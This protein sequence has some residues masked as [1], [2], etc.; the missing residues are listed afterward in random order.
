MHKSCMNCYFGELCPDVRVCEHFAPM[1]EDE[2]GADEALK[3]RQEYQQYRKAWIAYLSED[4]QGASPHR[5]N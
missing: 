5:F 3:R 1:E 4:G 2:T